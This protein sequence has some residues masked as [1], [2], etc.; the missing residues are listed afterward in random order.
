[1]EMSDHLQATT[2]LLGEK[3]S[4]THCN[5]RHGLQSMSE[6]FEVKKALHLPEIKSESS[7]L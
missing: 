4:S 5:G 2:D 3:S 7:G 6:R 1:M